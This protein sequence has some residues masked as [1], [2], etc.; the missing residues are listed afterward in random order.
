MRSTQTSA[1]YK[2]IEKKRT[3]YTPSAREL[4]DDEE[5]K[6][7]SDEEDE[8]T[9]SKQITVDPL[10]NTN[11]SRQPKEDDQPE[12]G[13]GLEMSDIQDQLQMSSIKQRHWEEKI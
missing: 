9:Q 10:G 7:S 8:V 1:Y 3:R 13:A 4:D 5:I 11:E 12:T 2:S 6:G